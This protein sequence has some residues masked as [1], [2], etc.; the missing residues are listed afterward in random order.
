[1]D[2]IYYVNFADCSPV[3]GRCNAREYLFGKRTD[4]RALMEFAAS[5]YQNSE[6][7]LTLDE[8]NLFYRLQTVFSHEEMMKELGLTDADLADV[9]VD[10]E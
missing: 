8:H 1:M 5:D 2:T 3:A 4:N 9:E 10:I 6:D 7:P